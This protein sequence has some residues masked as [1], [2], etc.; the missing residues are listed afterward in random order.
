[1]GVTLIWRSSEKASRLA[2]VSMSEGRGIHVAQFTD[3]RATRPG[4]MR[5]LNAVGRLAIPLV[6]LSADAWWEKACQAVPD[7]GEPAPE[8][9]RALEALVASLRDET[10]LHF[11]GRIAARDDTIRMAKNHLRIAKLLRER[12]EVAATQL[13][14]LVFIIGLPRTG[15]TFLHL[16][17][18]QDRRSRTIPYWESF[19]PIPPQPGPDR[20]PA[21][22]DA[23]LAQLERISPA[24]H[25]IHPMTA[26]MA[27]ECVALFMNELRT[28]QY[29]FQYFAPGYVGWLLAEDPRIAYQAYLRQ[30]RILQ[31]F[32]PAGERFLLKDPTHT[33]HLDSVLE[34][35][36]DAKLVFTHRDPA[37]TFS[38][39][40]SL[41]AHT[42]AIFSDEVDPVA[43]GEEVMA[44]YWPKAL[45]AS[46]AIRA[47]L[48][49]EQVADV[50]QADLARDP[51]GTAK[52]LYADLGFVFD[53]EVERAMQAFLEE[54]A[55]APERVHEHAPEGFGLSAPMLRERFEGYV[56]AYDL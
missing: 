39:L 14:A 4:W 56:E 28:L 19:D 32:R 42:R 12:P 52:Q 10:R 29:D 26:E 31:F 13:P 22:V 41:Y 30:L 27:E 2:K 50:R 51:I 23:L 53:D 7:A 38:S 11:V 49:P 1:M 48:P 20:R 40:C 18:S 3:A 5:A 43:L 8:A 15:T 6:P 25:A 46:Q 33:V 35:F 17:L 54:E 45:L 9:R 37:F 34:L 36:P 55:R 47:K 44:G 24:Y 16:L 21:Q